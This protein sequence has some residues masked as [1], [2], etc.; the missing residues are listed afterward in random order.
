MFGSVEVV[1]PPGDVLTESLAQ[2]DVGGTEVSLRL[3]CVAQSRVHTA[4]LG[5]DQRLDHGVREGGPTR[6]WECVEKVIDAYDEAGR[7]EPGAFTLS[8]NQEG[9]Y[10]RHPQMPSLRMSG[11]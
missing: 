3:A 5:C 10:L 4:G 7:P 11:P 9:Q 6:L 1:D 2:E 8:V